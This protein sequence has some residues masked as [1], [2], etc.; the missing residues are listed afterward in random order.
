MSQTEVVVIPPVQDVEG[1]RKQTVVQLNRL[2]TRIAQTDARTSPMSM[3]HQRLTDVPDPANPTDAVNLRTLKK[4]VQGLG[5]KQIQPTPPAPQNTAYYTI[6]WST[7]GTLA[8]GTAPPYIINAHRTGA[9]AMVR[10]YGLSSVGTATVNVVYV[11][12]GTGTAT[13]LLT[14]PLTY[15]TG[16]PA[17][18][19]T[20]ISP[21]PTLQI[22]D[23]VYGTILGAGTQ[24][25]FTLELLVNP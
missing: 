11:P 21:L 13:S 3:G 8:A 14:T 6:V 5:H 7:S 25:Y 23:V 1:L 17:S 18:S 12:Q 9:P 24:I 19:T 16:T 22:N 10:A 20:F 15:S 2:S 4:V